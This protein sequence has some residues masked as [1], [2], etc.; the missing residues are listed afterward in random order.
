MPD[1]RLTVKIDERQRAE[2]QR[3]LTGVRDGVRRAEVSAINKTVRDARTRI[4]R[5]I[6]EGAGIQKKYTDKAI[7]QEKANRQTLSGAVVLSYKPIPIYAFKARQTRKGVTFRFGA[8]GERKI[9]SHAFIATMASG[10]K[11][12]F[13]RQQGEKRAMYK[14]SYARGA[15]RNRYGRV[16]R[17]QIHEM[18]GPSAIAMFENSTQ[19]ARE[20]LDPSNGHIPQDLERYLSSAVDGL[21]AG[22]FPKDES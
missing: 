20:E 14:G 15:I 3:L 12:V 18:T 13:E 4:S 7:T 10:H 16:Y 9:F 2:L 21:L 19:I 8:D 1:G 17:Q 6:A 11:G 22:A 5:R